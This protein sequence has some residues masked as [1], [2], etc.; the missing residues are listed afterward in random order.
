MPVDDCAVRRPPVRLIT[1]APAS[2]AMRLRATWLAL[3]LLASLLPAPPV[4][5]DGLLPEVWL[6][7]LV[8]YTLSRV[9]RRWL[10]ERGG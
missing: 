7:A 3:L 4:A 5:A 2:Q 9:G 8:A 6:E 1:G 10:D